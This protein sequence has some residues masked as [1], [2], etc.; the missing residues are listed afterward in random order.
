M[1]RPGVTKRSYEDFEPFCRWERSPDQDVL[2]V[3]LQ[4]FKR[5]Q[6]KIQT[7]NMGVMTITGERCLD[8][9]HNRWARFSKETR[10][11]TNDIKTNEIHA[12]LST[13][14]LS[15]VLPKRPAVLPQ[16]PPSSSPDAGHEHHE[17]QPVT[18]TE[19][20]YH[21]EQST[22]VFDDQESEGGTQRVV[23]KDLMAPM[24]LRGVGRVTNVVVVVTVV[25]AVVVAVG[26]VLAGYGF[27]RSGSY[28]TGVSEL[29]FVIAG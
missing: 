29:G 21:E 24:K 27:R 11:P 25:V 6:L 14:I 22:R 20:H 17:Y 7:N 2:L 19:H 8:C 9:Q 18:G 16:P 28:A 26:A 23:G 12:K 5:Q 3:H 15:V 1:A 13:G 10:L 4:G